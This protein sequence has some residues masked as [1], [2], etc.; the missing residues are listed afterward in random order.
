MS[1]ARSIFQL[2]LAIICA[3]WGIVIAFHIGIFADAIFTGMPTSLNIVLTV[4]FFSASIIL[5]QNVV[6]DSLEKSEEID[7]NESQ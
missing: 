2:T 6:D 5:A 1:K 4:A 7:T 3:L